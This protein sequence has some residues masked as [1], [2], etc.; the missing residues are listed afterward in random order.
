MSS[1][2]ISLYTITRR[3]VVR[4]LRIWPQTLLPSA[5]TQS[6]YFLIFGSFVGRQI[7][8]VNGISYMQ[9]I[10]PG[11][12]MM[13]IITNAYM[14]SSSS[15][16]IGKFQRSIEEVLVSST[17]SWAIV[18][19]FAFGG[20]LRGFLVGSIVFI[21]SIIFQQPTV[22]APLIVLLFATLT[23][24]VFSL[25][26]LVNAV[27]AKKFDHIGIIPTFVLT[28]LTYLG[29]VFYSI[30]QLPEFWQGVSRFNPIVYMVDG[31]RFGFYGV[32]E[33]PVAYSALGLLLFS[34]IIAWVAMMLINKGVG[35][36]S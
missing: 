1:A 3:E 35:L 32:A 27:F 7:A 4:F 29:G 23:S 31:F 11:L 15:F 8:D 18:F 28:P 10:I 12:I 34:A 19:G 24:M 9:F 17:P 33:I 36:R 5:I 6:L 2:L 30:E 25:A 22:E 14:N 21:V 20:V 16:F 13:A 26:G